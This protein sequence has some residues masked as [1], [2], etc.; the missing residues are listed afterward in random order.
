M[1]DTLFCKTEVA[2]ISSALDPVVVVGLPRSGSSFLSHILSQIEGY[3]VFDDLSLLNQYSKL[4]S[5]K[6]TDKEFLHRVLY[7]LGWQIRARKRHGIYAIPNIEEHEIAH[8]NEAIAQA[9]NNEAPGVFRIQEEWLIRIA[10]RSGAKGWGFKMPQAYRRLD[11]LYDAYPNLRVIYLMRQPHDVLASYKHMYA[12]SQDGD[13]RRY[14]PLLY[15][16]YW[17]HAASILRKE[18]AKRPDTTMFLKFSDLKSDPLWAAR[19]LSKFMK[20]SPPQEVQ[21]PESS[22]SSFKKTSSR[23]GLTGLE[24]FIVNWICRNEMRHL[25]FA[26]KHERLSIG[27]LADF[28][29]TSW[30][31]LYFRLFVEPLEKRRKIRHI[32]SKAH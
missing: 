15:A 10:H 24:M 18:Q 11:E 28:S 3:Y 26:P 14:H 9:F 12:S 27:D 8:M 2:P 21:V 30:R 25:G 22:N 32:A 20:V 19:E 23:A 5:L 31:F 4:R 29:K 6:S 17:K 7:W 1:Q 13:S 16:F